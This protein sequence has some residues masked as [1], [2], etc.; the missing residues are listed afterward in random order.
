MEITMTENAF[1]RDAIM[2]IQRYLRHLSFHSE[3]IGDVPLDGI[4]D[5]ATRDALIEFQKENGLS[6]T[7]TVDRATWD[8]LKSEYDASV[9]QNS[10]PERIDLFPRSPAGYEIGEGDNGILVDAVQ[11]LLG[12]LERIYS[13]P[14]LERNGTFDKST[15]LAVRRFQERNNISPTGRVGRETWDALVIQHNLLDKY[16]E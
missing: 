14:E 3:S 6:P 8:I 10:P 2:N 1:E 11:Y 5:R 9:A 12:E 15:A 4:W 16:N 13:F 7:G